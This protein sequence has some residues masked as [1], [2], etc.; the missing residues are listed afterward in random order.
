MRK[1]SSLNTSWTIGSLPAWRPGLSDV[2]SL[3]LVSLNLAL[4]LNC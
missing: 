2:V 1:D 3:L 4:T